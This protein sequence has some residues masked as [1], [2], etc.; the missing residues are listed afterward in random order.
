MFEQLNWPELWIVKR[1]KTNLRHGGLEGWRWL[2]QSSLSIQPISI[3][4]SHPQTTPPDSTPPSSPHTAHTPW[5][6]PMPFPHLTLLWVISSLR[7]PLNQ[8]F[9]PPVPLQSLIGFWSNSKCSWILGSDWNQPVSHL[10]IFWGWMLSRCP[11]SISNVPI[12]IVPIPTGPIVPIRFIDCTV[13]KQE[14]V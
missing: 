11:F 2:L 7:N 14:T 4:P 10:A 6:D 5:F 13:E 1:N 12:P 9:S 8:F 3:S